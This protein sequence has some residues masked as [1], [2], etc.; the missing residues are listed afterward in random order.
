MKISLLTQIQIAIDLYS[1]KNSENCFSTVKI[2]ESVVG[3]REDFLVSSFFHIKCEKSVRTAWLVAPIQDSTPHCVKPCS[4][5]HSV[6]FLP[7]DKG[8]QYKPHPP[9][10]GGESSYNGIKVT[11]A[12][13]PD[14]LT[15]VNNQRKRILD[16]WCF[17]EFMEPRVLLQVCISLQT[18]GMHIS[19]RMRISHAILNMYLACLV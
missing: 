16:S 8:Q 11:G 6:H 12:K 4:V 2:Y 19:A 13:R 1:A 9:S 14:L 15:V 3:E 5:A 17:A 7:E 10:E 18:A